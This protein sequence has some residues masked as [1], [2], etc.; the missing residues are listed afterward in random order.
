MRFAR[1]TKSTAILS[2]G[3]VSGLLVGLMVT[4]T[5]ASALTG[6]P[7]ASLTVS[8]A[9]GPAPCA[10]TFDGS[11]STDP[12]SPLATWTLDFGD[13]TQAAE[14]TG[15]PPAED[16]P[17]GDAPLAVNFDGSGSSSSSTLS[18]WSLDFGD[19]SSPATGAGPPPSDAPY[20]YQDQG[21]YRP[22]LTVWD[23]GGRS[24]STSTAVE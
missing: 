23:D 20:T 24:A 4:A 17:A 12:S 7:A 18:S 15:T 11:A 14:G 5:S 13:G 21:S 3:I 2:F 6:A 9:G 22:T 8:G 1:F 10:V 19:G 16:L